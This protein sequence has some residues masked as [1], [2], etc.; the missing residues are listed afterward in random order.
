MA[1][2]KRLSI[3]GIVLAVGLYFYMDARIPEPFPQKFKLMTMDAFMKT[4]GNVVSIVIY[5]V[6]FRYM[7][8]F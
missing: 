7:W 3:W 6:W 1:S 2:F 8:H 4:Y 5:I